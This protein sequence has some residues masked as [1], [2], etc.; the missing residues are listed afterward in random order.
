M[1]QKKMKTHLSTQEKDAVC[2][3]FLVGDIVKLQLR[4]YL[5]HHPPATGRTWLIA[6][7]P[8]QRHLNKYTERMTTIAAGIACLNHL[9]S[10]PP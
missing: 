1:W 8:A 7:F 9:D 6:G 4:Y 3:L 2:S 10:L 5:A